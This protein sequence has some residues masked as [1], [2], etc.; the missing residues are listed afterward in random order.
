MMKIPNLLELTTALISRPRPFAGLDDRRRIE[1]Y[2][3]RE[4]ERAAELKHRAQLFI[5]QPLISIRFQKY[6]E[7]DTTGGREAFQEEYFGHRKRLNVMVMAYLL[8]GDEKYLQEAEDA[9][10]AICDEYT[11]C[12]HAHLNGR[13]LDCLNAGGQV[14]EKDGKVTSYDDVSHDRHLDLFACETA[15]DLAESLRILGAGITP[16]V[17]HRA[18]REIT[19]RVFVPY[20]EFNRIFHFELD[21]SNWSA[22][23][24]GSIGMA[25]LYLIDDQRMLAP[26]LQRVI[27]DLDVFIASYGDDGIGLEGIGYW[28]YGFSNFVYFADLLREATA[29]KINLF[30]DEKVKKVA[31]FPAAAYLY[32][33]CCVNFSDCRFQYPCMREVLA[34]LLDIYPDMPVP[35][36]YNLPPVRES[37]KTVMALREIFWEGGRAAKAKAPQFRDRR[38]YYPDAQWLV[39]GSRVQDHVFSFVIK[40]GNN[41]EPH[42][43]NDLGH[44]MVYL[45]E[46]PLLCDLGSGQYTKEYFG[47]GRYDYLVNSSRGHSVPIIA[48]QLQQPGSDRR[49]VLL[50]VNTED[51]AQAN[52]AL[53]LA[54]AYG[55]EELESFIRRTAIDRKQ[56]RA[57]LWDT[58]AFAGEQLKVTERFVSLVKPE[59]TNQGVIIRKDEKQIT[60]RSKT[61]GARLSICTEEYMRHDLATGTAYLINLDYVLTKKNK[62]INITIG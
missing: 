11:W 49:A 50:A 42:N 59:I 10:W 21:L 24:G 53:E 22:V 18:V 30:H 29:G 2:L 25:A 38:D 34:R 5:E 19:R 32:K 62:E 31:F 28:H 41:G 56:G 35:T 39:S 4:P 14:G 43:H 37:L 61:P 20:L 36:A 52:I 13:S 26:V 6:K 57:E 8:F 60:L 58:F 17:R 3:Q 9:I 16:I 33:D 23:C 54:A 46:V 55:V 51:E 15:K 7:F 27:S 44:F 40:G 12:L 1:E 48:G 47:D 45:D